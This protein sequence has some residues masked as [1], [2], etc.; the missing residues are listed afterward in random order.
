MLRKSVPTAGLAFQLSY[1]Y[2]KAMDNASTVYNGD[3]ANSAFTQNDPTCWSCKKA[4]VSFD[5]PPHVVVI[6][7]YHLPFDK[8]P[9]LPNPLTQ[10]W[11]FGE[12]ATASSG[13]P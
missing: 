1:T 9:P 3:A 12:T 8:A 2:S 4:R 7:S 6:F 10:G 5:V 13:F 11:P